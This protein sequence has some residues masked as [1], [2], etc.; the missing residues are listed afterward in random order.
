MATTNLIGLKLR[1]AEIGSAF[2]ISLADFVDVVNDRLRAIGLIFEIIAWNLRLF[3]LIGATCL[4][5]RGILIRRPPL[6]YVNAFHA[7]EGGGHVL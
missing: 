2:R 3:G 7:I 5:I 6:S 1:R 4:P